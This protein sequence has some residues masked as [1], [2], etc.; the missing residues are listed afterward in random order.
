MLREE[1]THLLQGR[2]SQVGRQ[3]RLF[4]EAPVEHWL[5]CTQG[6]ADVIV[7][8]AV[9]NDDDHRIGGFTNQFYSCH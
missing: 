3:R 1:R 9:D 2:L 8:V 5:W 6:A 4:R 7:S